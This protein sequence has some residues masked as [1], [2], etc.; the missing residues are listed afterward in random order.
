MLY[1]KTK[2]TTV[3]TT[4]FGTALWLHAQVASAT[5]FEPLGK[6]LSTLL[7]STKPFTKKFKRGAEEVVLFYTKDDAGKLKKI[8]VIEK[9]VY[10]P[11]CTHTWAVGIDAETGKVDQVRVV[12][13]SCPH[14]FP[15]QK[16]GYLSQY[17]GKGPADVKKLDDDIKTIAKAT[18]SSKLA[19]NAVK[20][21]IQLVSTV[22]GKL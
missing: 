7:E 12:E 20:K 1:K 21:S 8:A 14:A 19:T 17:K 18:G 16:E 9:G 3:I 11:N 10:E 15:T 13:M 5:Q 22:K 2:S 4:F 6:A